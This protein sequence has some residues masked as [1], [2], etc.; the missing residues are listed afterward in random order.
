MAG[1][2]EILAKGQIL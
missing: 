2:L 1:S